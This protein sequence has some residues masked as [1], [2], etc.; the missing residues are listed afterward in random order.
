MSKLFLIFITMLKYWIY[1]VKKI[2]SH[3]KK[4]A[5]PTPGSHEW[6]L[7][8]L[9][10]YSFPHRLLITQLLHLFLNF[11][12]IIVFHYIYFPCFQKTNEVYSIW[13]HFDVNPKLLQLTYVWYLINH[14]LFQ[15]WPVCIH[16]QDIYYLFCK[17][18]CLK[19]VDAFIAFCNFFWIIL[20]GIIILNWIVTC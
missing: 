8:R 5:S 15:I 17:I 19:H 18:N 4:T 7:F 11:S 6:L 1:E 14:F 3:I 20:H 13:Y 12:I 9:N 16:F 2:P 10:L